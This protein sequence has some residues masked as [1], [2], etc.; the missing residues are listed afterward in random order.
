G[1]A[2]RPD[3]WRSRG[4]RQF[5]RRRCRR[6]SQYQRDRRISLGAAGRNLLLRTRLERTY[7]AQDRL[8]VRAVDEG[9]AEGA[10]P[11]DDCC[12]ETG[13]APS[14]YALCTRPKTR[15]AASLLGSWAW[16]HGCGGSRWNYGR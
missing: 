2:H 1:L 13:L 8:F 14:P 16:S 9:A 7:A 11:A 6:L 10:L 4:R 5:E 12:V 15:Q 3:Q